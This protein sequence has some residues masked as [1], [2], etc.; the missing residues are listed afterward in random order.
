MLMMP[1]MKCASSKDLVVASDGGSYW[2][3]TSGPCCVSLAAPLVNYRVEQARKG[4]TESLSWNPPYEIVIVGVY[5]SVCEK[6]LVNQGR[7]QSTD[8]R[9]SSSISY[10]LLVG[11][12]FR[13]A[14]AFSITS[15]EMKVCPARGPL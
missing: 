8:R 4:R 1:I 15:F 3:R 12:V 10:G 6:G 5:D 13:F 7:R 11:S 14:C 9:P 2:D